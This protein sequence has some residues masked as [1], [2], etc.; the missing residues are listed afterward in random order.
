M[1]KIAEAYNALDSN[2]KKWYEATGRNAFAN[3][4]E[5]FGKDVMKLGP[6]YKSKVV[7]KE[8]KEQFGIVSDESTVETSVSDLRRYRDIVSDVPARPADG[9]PTGWTMRV[10][11]RSGKSKWVKH[12]KYWYSPVESYRFLSMTKI[13][14]FLERLEEVGGDEV[15]AYKLCKLNDKKRKN[16]DAADIVV[17]DRKK[18]KRN[19]RASRKKKIVVEMDEDKDEDVNESEEDEMPDARSLSITAYAI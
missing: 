4:K 12:D 9:L 6:R 8:Q 16:T 5:E 18:E 7:G 3:Y 1:C 15:M 13:Q 10:I 14:Q 11:R 2:A 19:K 17:Y